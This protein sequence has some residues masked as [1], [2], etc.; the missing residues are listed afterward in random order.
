MK[1]LSNYEISEK[2]WKKQNFYARV[3]ADV[4]VIYQMKPNQKL[5]ANYELAKKIWERANYGIK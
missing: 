5:L 2:A 3:I 1:K 4:V